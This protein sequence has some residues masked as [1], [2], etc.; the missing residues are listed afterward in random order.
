VLAAALLAGLT[1]QLRFLPGLIMV[2]G[3]IAALEMRLR[4]GHRPDVVR[5]TGIA[6][7]LAVSF[8]GFLLLAPAG[9]AA[10]RAGDWTTAFLLFGPVVSLPLLTGPV[11]ARA[12][13]VVTHWVAMFALA[14]APILTAT[15]FVQ[16]PVLPAVAVELRVDTPTDVTT[17]AT[18]APAVAPTT[19]TT[20][21]APAPGTRRTIIVVRGQVITVD[22][23]STTLLEPGGNVRFVPNGDVVSQVLC[24]DSQEPPFSSVTVHGWPVEAAMLSWLAPSKTEKQPD[25]RCRGRVVTPQ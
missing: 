10:L 2:L 15:I 4:Y 1:W 13:R 9:L 14:V 20:T 19:T 23:R 22:D 6:I 11:P 24:P 25:P 16:A 12:G 5:I 21:T 7:P 3:S 18:A 8:L 17:D